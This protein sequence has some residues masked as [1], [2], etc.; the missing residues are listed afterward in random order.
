M[1]FL[2]K[3]HVYVQ[4]WNGTKPSKM[5]MLCASSTAH[6]PPPVHKRHRSARHIS[7]AHLRCLLP[8]QRQEGHVTQAQRQ[9][10][11]CSRWTAG[12]RGPLLHI[13]AP[14]RSL[15]LLLKV[16]MPTLKVSVDF[17][18]DL[19]RN[20][21]RVRKQISEQTFIP[22]RCHCECWSLSQYLLGERQ[23]CISSTAAL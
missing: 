16:Q 21:E 13:G 1:P 17:N 15:I 14:Q 9:P 22:S 5:P 11:G 4:L 10:A 7:G 19:W 18:V 2:S 6:L 3:S 23:K 12:S 20:K 8:V